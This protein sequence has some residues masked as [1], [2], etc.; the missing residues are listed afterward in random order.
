MNESTTNS[1]IPMNN[2]TEA[3]SEAVNNDPRA[4]SKPEEKKLT[5]KQKWILGCVIF[6]F[7]GWLFDG[8]TYDID[9][10][11]A[12]IEIVLT[13]SDDLDSATLKVLSE[14]YAVVHAH[15][16]LKK[17]D[18]ALTMSKTGRVDQDGHAVE[19]D[20]NM[21]NFAWDHGRIEEILKYKNDH[22]FT[23]DEILRFAY[24]T[25][26]EMMPDADLLQD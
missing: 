13:S 14:G 10:D 20:I 5:T 16:H 17:V 8:P 22:L 7:I 2:K 3:Q 21:G 11:T 12:R 18:I 19:Q 6:A 4:K 24:K 15:P 23:Q 9:G 25:A 1:N 26:I